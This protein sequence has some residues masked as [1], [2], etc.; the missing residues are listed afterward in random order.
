MAARRLARLLLALL[1]TTAATAGCGGAPTGPSAP[2][3]GTEADARNRLRH[4]LDGGDQAGGAQDEATYAR[5]RNE[6]MVSCMADAGFTYQPVEPPKTAPQSLGL[7]DEEFAERYGF[8]LS[9]LIDLPSGQA[10]PDPNRETR[11]GLSQAARSAFDRTLRGCTDRATREL[12]PPPGVLQLP[13]GATS[14]SLR[15]ALDRARS[16]ARVV[17]A[18]RNYERCLAARGFSGTSGEQLREQIEKQVAPL[19]Q[20]YQARRSELSGKEQ[21]VSRLRV[22]DALDAGQLAALRQVQQFELKAAAAERACGTDLY[23]IAGEV[24]REYTRKLLGSGR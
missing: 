11:N 12:G 23:R 2:D 4:A 21:D 20:A 18:Q 6:V 1:L 5:R 22:E 9:T 7:S 24:Q 10:P 17:A 8:G 3:A 19:R 16:D 14:A 13:I 15:D